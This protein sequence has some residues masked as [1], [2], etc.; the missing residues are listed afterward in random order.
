MVQQP[1]ARVQ[2]DVGGWETALGIHVGIHLEVE[3]AF[4]FA[5]LPGKFLRIEGNVLVAGGGGGH[6]HEIGDE[7][8]AAQFPAARADAADSAGFLARTDLFHFDAD[9]ERFRQHLN[10]GAE[11]HPVVGDI[12]EDGFGLVALVF[13]VADFHVQVKVG[14]N[15]PG[16]Y[17]RLVFQGDGLFPLFNV[18]GLR[19]AVDFLQTALLGVRPFQAHLL[20]DQFACQ[21]HHADVMPQGCFH[22][23]DVPLLQRQFRGVGVKSFPR[24]F[25]PHLHNLRHRVGFGQVA[26][27][28]MHIQFAC[29]QTVVD[30]G[31][32]RSRVFRVRLLLFLL[33]V[34]LLDGLLGCRLYGFLGQVLLFYILLLYIVFCFLHLLHGD[35]VLWVYVYHVFKSVGCFASL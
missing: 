4:Q 35:W 32:H 13:H 10:Q 22:R 29:Q 8:R 3:A 18:V 30:G 33:F 17:H 2:R 12:I 34:F 31:D 25:E 7:G 15:L 26:E 27:P 24:V 23:H 9:V 1:V 14:G 11:I 20:F 6:R 16:A 28:V 19:L 5:A 21:R